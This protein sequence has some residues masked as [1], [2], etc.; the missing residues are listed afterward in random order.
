MKNFILYACIVCFIWFFGSCKNSGDSISTKSDTGQVIKTVADLDKLV[1]QN[2]KDASLWHKRGLYYFNNKQYDK[3]IEDVRA[4]IKI[5]S[6]KAGYYLTLSDCY[7]VKNQSNLTREML[8]KAIK[9]DS[10]NTDA[11]LKLA[12]LHLYVRLYQDALNYVNKA[13]MVNENLAKA[14]FI[15]GITYLEIGDTLK[16][17][18]S[19][20]T[21]VEQDQEYYHA[22]I[23][24]GLLYALKGDPIAIDYYNNALNLNPKSEEAHY[25]LGQFYLN[26]NDFNKAIE[27]FTTV[28]NINPKNKDAHFSLGYIHFEKLKVY[29]E[30]LKHFTNAANS[31]PKFYKAFFMV[32]LT[33]ETLGDI[34]NALKFYTRA[35]AIN[36]E[37]EKA[38]E[39]I[40]RIQK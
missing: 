37:Y 25:N 40:K 22:Y 32:G 2:P 10:S 30:A 18:S 38:K 15:K 9:V 26:K 31:D 6:T 7:L 19:F 13:L 14:Y 28:I 24:L 5:D 3:A 4:A 1:A 8:L 20:K 33:Y 39:G 11:L 16:A 34:S 29:S 12:E 21:T 27:Q 35:V 17:V 23:Q 36:P